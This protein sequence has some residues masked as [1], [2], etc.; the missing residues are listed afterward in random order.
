MTSVTA[1]RQAEDWFVQA[2]R[3]EREGDLDSA[4]HAYRQAAD[5][6]VAAFQSVPTSRPRIRGILAVSAVSLYQRAG[7]WEVGIR[8]AEAF[9]NH[10]DL[11]KFYRRQLHILSAEMELQAAATEVQP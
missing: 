2:E 10:G 7:T 9:L 8:F 11:P 1:H 4:S 3:F 6:E 5:C